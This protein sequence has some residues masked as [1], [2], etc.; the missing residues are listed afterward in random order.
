ML[1]NRTNFAVAKCAAKFAGRYAINGVYFSKT[2][3][4]ATDGRR[5]ACVTY[6]KQDGAEDFPTVPGAG[7]G[8][9]TSPVDALEPFTIDASDLRVLGKDI[10]T[11]KPVL[12]LI[13][14]DVLETNANGHAAFAYTDLSNAQAPR[15]RKLEGEF[16]RYEA[17]IPTP[18]E[19]WARV[20][21]N[22]A[23]LAEMLGIVAKHGGEL[24][25]VTIHVPPRVKNEHGRYDPQGPILLTA[26]VGDEQKFT[27]VLMPI[28]LEE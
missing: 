27:G 21:V 9:P 11:S 10:R 3:T 5:L 25:G 26:K 20:T 22:P 17:V 12:N 13:A 18:D 4:V 1:I 8:A 7:E 28:A 15:I 16:P 14:L 2:G 19:K 6:P 23:Y 24:R